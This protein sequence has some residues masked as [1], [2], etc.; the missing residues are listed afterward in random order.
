MSFYAFDQN[1]AH[2]LK[3]I[4]QRILDDPNNIGDK[5]DNKDLDRDFNNYLKKEDEKKFN[6]EYKKYIKQ[7]FTPMNLDKLT[8]KDIYDNLINTYQNIINDLTNLF[9]LSSDFDRKEISGHKDSFYQIVFVYIKNI[10][11]I[12][13][14]EE[15]MLYV[16]ISF[17]ILS[18]LIYFIFVTK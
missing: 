4:S 8:I 5:N 13:F 15:R 3:N 11:N 1:L 16:G 2:N 18:F 12:F 6:N 9:F 10:F 14:S 17:C 7:N